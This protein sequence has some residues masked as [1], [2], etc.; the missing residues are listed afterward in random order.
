MAAELAKRAPESW[1]RE[2]ALLSLRQSRPFCEAFFRAM[3]AEGL[4]ERHP[5]LTDRF[6]NETLYFESGPFL[7]V[8]SG[9]QPPARVAAVLRLL[10]DRAEPL[11][12]LEAICRRL[13]SS[14]D[15]TTASMAGEILVRRGWQPMATASEELFV[16]EKSGVTFVRI[17]AGVFVMGDD[18]GKMNE[19]P[20]HRM[21]IRQDFWL[22]KYPVT[23]AQYKRFLIAQR[24]RARK[25]PYWDD[26]RFNQPEQPVVAVTWFEAYAFSEWVGGRLPTE[27]EWEYACR[28]GST[29]KYCFGDDP[30]EL[31]EY[32]WFDKNCGG[33]TQPVGTKKPNAWGLH[34]MHGN[35]W[36]WCHDAYQAYPRAKPGS[37]IDDA[38]ESGET[39]TT[40]VRVL[41]GGPF[42]GMSSV[43]RSSGR[44]FNAPDIDDG[45]VSFRPSRT[46][47]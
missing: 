5:D 6:L 35:V 10:R 32:A 13:S 37:V 15:A 36:E 7:E 9:E 12:E 14:S 44:Y 18:N 26:R 16:D 2:S 43:V 29:T 17:R 24:G 39:Y 19:R 45:T 47:R 30:A 1:W 11:P 23:N 34:D 41:R 4:A 3:L 38:L 22:A 28:A 31:G 8:L 42:G 27:A 21:R 20:A 46:Y 33:Q 25:P 40:N